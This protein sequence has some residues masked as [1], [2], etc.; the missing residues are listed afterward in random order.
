MI[1]VLVYIAMKNVLTDNDLAD[2]EEVPLSIPVTKFKT[3]IYIQ[4][5][6]FDSERLD[7][8]LWIK[9]EIKVNEKKQ[10]TN[11]IKTVIWN[12][13]KSY[14]FKM[15]KTILLKFWWLRKLA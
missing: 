13:K 1:D 8:E 14:L 10:L 3:D 5:K 9:E 2:P 12:G 4:K 7:F 6:E 15:A 11:L